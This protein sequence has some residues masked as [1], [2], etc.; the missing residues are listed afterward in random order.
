[1]P[2]EKW[3]DVEIR[4]HPDARGIVV[5]EVLLGD[6]KSRTVNL[7]PVAFPDVEVHVTEDLT[8]LRATMR[9]LRMRFMKGE[10]TLFQNVILD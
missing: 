3:I 9:N 10:L 6:E 7:F 1:M 4:Q 2:V 5:F 8:P